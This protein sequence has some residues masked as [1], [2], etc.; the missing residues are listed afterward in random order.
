MILIAI[1]AAVFAL[2]LDFIFGDPVNRYH[3]T[4]WIGKLISKFVPCTKSTNHITE[5]IK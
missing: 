1:I 4:A 3:P 2:A 5:K